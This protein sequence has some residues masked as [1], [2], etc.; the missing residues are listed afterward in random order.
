MKILFI[1]PSNRKSLEVEVKNRKSP[2]NAL[3]AI[4]HLR[5]YGHNAYFKDTPRLSEKILNFFLFPINGLFLKQIEIDFKLVRIIVLLPWIAKSDIVIANT[6]GVALPLCFLKKIGVIRTPLIYAVGLFYVEG[7]LEKSI[8]R[9]SPSLFSAFYKWII[10]SA[11]QILYHS[12]AEKEKLINLGVYN[13]AICTFTPMGSDGKF[14]NQSRFSKIKSIKNTVVAVGKDRA[15]DYEL[16]LACANS[17]K[18]LRVIIICRKENIVNFKIPKNVKVLYEIPYEE[19]AKWYRKAEV[20]VI[21]LKEIRKSTGQMTFTDSLQSSRPI[22]IS[23]VS[24]ISHYP[25]KTNFNAVLV[26]PQNATALAKNIKE[27]I[28]NSKLQKKLVKNAIILKKRY[29][30]YQ[31]GKELENVVERVSEKVQL[32]PLSKK[33]LEF[34]RK[35]RNE[36]RRSFLSQGLISR[37]DQKKWFE[38]Y[39][40]NNNDWVFILEKDKEPIGAGSIYDTDAVKGEAK[41]GRFVIKKQYRHKGYGVILLK[42]V[43]EIAFGELNLKKLNLEVLA[44]NISALNLYKKSNFKVGSGKIIKGQKVIVMSKETK[45]GPFSKR[46]LQFNDADL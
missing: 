28:N 12:P 38:K 15:R 22:I 5:K 45:L 25:L 41:I 7:G 3:Y 27:L 24:G 13:P 40:S 36:N 20:I 32:I 11:D 18:S 29:T 30:T 9:K 39:K 17:L 31:Y 14:F 2:D 23:A 19:V 1:Y 42:K 21:P 46:I 10:S 26:P 16:L 44:R 43:E 33:H 34:L 8:E 35:L 4:N 6:D 37:E